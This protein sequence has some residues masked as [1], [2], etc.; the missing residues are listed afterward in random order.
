VDTGILLVTRRDG[1]MLLPD[2][3]FAIIMYSGE[4]SPP[5]EQHIEDVS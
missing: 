4:L 1:K 2:H 3:L 5:H